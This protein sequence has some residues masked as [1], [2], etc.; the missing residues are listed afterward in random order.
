M[1]TSATAENIRGQKE[2]N[3]GT[4][5]VTDETLISLTSSDL[6]HDLHA[7]AVVFHNKHILCGY[8][9]DFETPT[10]C[11]AFAYSALLRFP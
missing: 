7:V 6:V 4:S 5:D 10:H 11:M 8:I 2:Q 3:Q 9:T 1:F